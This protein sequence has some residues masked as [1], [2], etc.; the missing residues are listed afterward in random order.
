MVLNEVVSALSDKLEKM[1][2]ILNKEIEN[3]NIEDISLENLTTDYETQLPKL[4][5]ELEVKL[6]RI[7]KLGDKNEQVTK[8]LEVS[9]SLSE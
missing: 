7:I 1:Q 2:S 4:N 8:L 9:S 3:I 6:D 5:P